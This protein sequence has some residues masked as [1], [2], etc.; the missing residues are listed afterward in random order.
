MLLIKCWP[1]ISSE[2][3]RE[4]NSHA[5]RHLGQRCLW[6][7]FSFSPFSLNATI[8][9]I[10]SVKLFISVHANG[11]FNRFLQILAVSSSLQLLTISCSLY[12]RW[13]IQ[14]SDY[15]WCMRNGNW[16]VSSQVHC[17]LTLSLSFLNNE[18]YVS[19]SAKKHNSR[20]EIL[21]KTDLKF[22]SWTLRVI[23][24]NSW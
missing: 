13:I 17:S 11:F 5:L 19:T 22:K 15:D 4:N 2:D 23:N 12:S 7:S 14:S 9:H 21:L 20:I 1:W 8:R 3:F 16:F 10:R 24:H 18:L 6:T